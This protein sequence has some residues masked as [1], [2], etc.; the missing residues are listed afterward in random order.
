MSLRIRKMDLHV[1]TPASH[2]FVDKAVMARE[3]V[4]H[5]IS[6][7]LDGIGVTDPNTVDFIDQI[8]SAAAG[9]SLVILRRGNVSVTS[10]RRDSSIPVRRTNKLIQKMSV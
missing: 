9:T 1:H 8:Q 7:G 3:I 10:S 4:D 2:D 6:E 5:A